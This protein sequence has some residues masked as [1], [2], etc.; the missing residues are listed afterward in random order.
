[1]IIGL[2]SF[3][4]CPKAKLGEKDA[5][6]MNV[7]LDNLAQSL[8]SIGHT[9]YVFTRKHDFEED[10][11]Y[12]IGAR[13]KLVHINA[14]NEEVSKKELINLIFEFSSNVQSYMY[15]EGIELEILHTHYWLSGLVGD[16]L[17]KRWEIPH[18]ITFHTL[19]KTK[20]RALAAGKEHFSRTDSEYKLME[21]AD[22]ILVLT[23]K[24]IQDIRQL[25]GEFT[26]KI[27][28]VPPGIDIKMFHASGTSGARD[29]LN[30]PKDSQ[31]ILFVGRIDPIKG[32]EILVQAVSLIASK[33]DVFLYIVGGADEENKYLSSIKSLVE[34]TG[35]GEKVVFTGPVAHDELRIYYNAADVFVLPSHY[36]SLGFVAIEAM[37]CGTPVV[38]SRVGG[39]P[40]IVDHGSTG[41]LIPWR[42]PE[43]FA[44]QI[45]V[46]L[47]NEDLSGFMSEQ[48]LKRAYSLSWDSTAK[49][50]S[51]Y[52][53]EII[54]DS[55]S[56]QAV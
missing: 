21:S 18:V 53:A 47:Q 2:V 39:I 7:Y 32:L 9:V 4:T 52:Y 56:I 27:A 36:E 11:E 5:G 34:E 51:H 50:V 43:A 44:G 37:A 6:G 41:Y 40:S 55:V 22:G 13:S 16:L 25:Y 12:S 24:E 29:E 23:Q 20:L 38:A 48:A 19:A 17:S 26:N 14:G 15:N 35:L 49:T 1:M 33:K 8:D 28:V 46:L 10:V 30:I 31:M 3:H 42:C 45:E 54:S